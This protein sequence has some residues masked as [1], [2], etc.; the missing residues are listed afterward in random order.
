MSERIVHQA[1]ALLGLRQYREAI[2][3]VLANESDLDD[4][5]RMPALL[6]AFGAAEEAGFR[7]DAARLAR[8]IAVEDP[9]VPSIQRYL[10]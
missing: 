7:D 9:K 3:Y 5:S 1:A 4:D 2:D 10:R 8:M 6:Q